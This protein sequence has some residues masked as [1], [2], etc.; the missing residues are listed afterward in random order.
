ML[1]LWHSFSPQCHN[2]SRLSSFQFPSSSAR[3]A[4]RGFEWEVLLRPSW[5]WVSTVLYKLLL[6]ASCH[7]PGFWRIWYHV[8]VYPPCSPFLLGTFI[9]C[10]WAGYWQEHLILNQ[11]RQWPPDKYETVRL[12][13]APEQEHCSETPMNRDHCQC[14]VPMFQFCSST[15]HCGLCHC[16]VTVGFLWTFS[17]QTRGL[18][19]YTAMLI[20]ILFYQLLLL[21]VDQVFPCITAEDLPVLQVWIMCSCS[22]PRSK[23]S[24]T[25][26][27]MW[28]FFFSRIYLDCA[29][30]KVFVPQIHITMI[31]P[32][33]CHILESF[34]MWHKKCY[35]L[36]QVSAF[37]PSMCR[38]ELVFLLTRRWESFQCSATRTWCWW[39]D[40]IASEVCL[41]D[42][43]PAVYSWVFFD[44]KA[45]L[46]FNCTTEEG[47][48]KHIFCDDR[49]AFRNWHPRIGHQPMK[50]LLGIWKV[51][52]STV[53]CWHTYTFL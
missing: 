31:I 41:G 5:G 35:F 47:C 30:V 20:R 27:G 16:A 40:S 46:C 17:I 2:C 45:S 8:S 29:E 1:Y 37:S 49:V 13:L 48:L 9:R 3:E 32:F 11:L 24:W 44:C 50:R 43:L 34:M 10:N 4:M 14:G 28:A 52:S 18:R 53:L 33:G 36:S 23:T 51:L 7:D 12:T 42:I 15:H 25:T 19:C 38:I 39:L 21:L 6:W 22:K 26:A